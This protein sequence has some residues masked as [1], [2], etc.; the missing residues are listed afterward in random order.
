MLNI[1]DPE[2]DNSVTLLDSILNCCQNAVSGGGAYAFVSADGV[3]ILMNDPIFDSFLTRG[4]FHL[5]I[6][7]DD[8]TNINTLTQLTSIINRH[9]NLHVK[10][11]L[12]N[13][14]RSTFHPKFCWFDC[15]NCGY[16]IIGSG[17]LTQKGMQSNREAFELK[18]VSIH[19]LNIIKETWDNWLQSI[20]H[21]LFPIDDRQILQRA[22]E[23]LTRMRE[24]HA[25]ERQRVPL[26]TQTDTT[27]NIVEEQE[28]T[29]IYTDEIGAWEYNNT[30]RVLLAEIPRGGSRWN[31]A[32]FDQNTF[33]TYFESRAGGRNQQSLIL[34]LV[35][36]NGNLGKIMVRP[37]VSVRSHNYRVELQ[38]SP[39][40]Q[41]PRTGYVL[42]TFVKLASRTFIYSLIFP[43]NVEYNNL[44]NYLNQRRS[45]RGSLVRHEITPQ[46]LLELAPTLSI[47]RYLN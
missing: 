7:M 15:E 4:H 36:Q 39:D 31:Q 34:R 38:I 23:N 14:L 25:I 16:T 20:N 5:I 9:P 18:E 12:H 1:Q 6:G 33:E 28:H 27:T 46:Q 47:L 19:E 21:Y 40:M 42:G 30:A 24:I 41:Y 45:R 10:A 26:R 11:L 2:Y 8:I 43:D 3:S 22:N 29:N 32:N 44:E 37:P 17:N 13:T 35:K